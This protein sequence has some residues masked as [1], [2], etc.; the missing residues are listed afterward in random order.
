MR[1]PAA[2]VRPV[3][4]LLLLLLIVTRQ[5]RNVIAADPDGLDLAAS[6]RAGPRDLSR[7]HTIL[8]P[9]VREGQGMRMSRSWRFPTWRN[10]AGRRTPTPTRA[11][12]APAAVITLQLR[13]RRRPGSRISWILRRLSMTLTGPTSWALLRR[14]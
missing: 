14:R 12:A 4:L 8:K 6:G 1:R 13:A 11:R 10:G 9:T 7:A 2:D 3:R 5:L